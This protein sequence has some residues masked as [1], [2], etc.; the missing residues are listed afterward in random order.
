M[1]GQKI[2]VTGAPGLVG[3]ALTLELC[4]NN[5]VYGPGPVQ[6][7]GDEDEAGA[8]WRV[9]NSKGR[10]SGKPGRSAR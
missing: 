3:S 7:R 8:G 10:P 6:R 9:D 2:L 1:K 5:E 4:K